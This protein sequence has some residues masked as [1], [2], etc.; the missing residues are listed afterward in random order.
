I[1]G[2]GWALGGAK[3]REGVQ[4]PTALPHGPGCRRLSAACPPERAGLCSEAQPA[5][6]VGRWGDQDGAYPVVVSRLLVIHVVRARV[7]RVP[8]PGEM[9]E[10]AG[11]GLEGRLAGGVL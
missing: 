2:A 10:C 9:G 7:V 11:R 6:P 5:V 3:G 4:A 8:E 1:T